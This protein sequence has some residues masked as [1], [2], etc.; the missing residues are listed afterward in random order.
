M[1]DSL[2]IELGSSVDRN[3]SKWPILGTYIWPNYY[4]FDTF[5]QEINYLKSWISDRLNWMD[6]QILLLNSKSSLVLTDFYLNQNY[7]NPF[8][9]ITTLSYSLPKDEE[10]NITI[11]DIMGR[12]VKTIQNSYQTKGFKFIKWDA[13][14]DRNEPVS[15][16]LYLYTIQA[17]E[18]RQT[19]KMVLLK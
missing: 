6:S 18:F 15:A 8:N 1:I 11:F 5:D 13:K 2:V 3:F 17:G 9:L 19:K 7:P 14:N 12:P 16:G 10:V 4:V